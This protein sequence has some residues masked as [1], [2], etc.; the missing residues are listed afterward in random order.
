MENKLQEWPVISGGTVIGIKEETP[1]VEVATRFTTI[2]ADGVFQTQDKKTY[3]ATTILADSCL[4][5]IFPRKIYSG[6][7]KKVLSQPLYAMVS[8]SIAQK[9]GGDVVGKTFSLQ[10]FP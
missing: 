1:E 9:I 3:R 7:P 8:R 6:N 4:F 2:V 5:D 10:T